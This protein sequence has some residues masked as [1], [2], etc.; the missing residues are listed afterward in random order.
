MPRTL[1]SPPPPVTTGPE[2][3]TAA[4]VDASAL[5][6]VR[7]FGVMLGG[8]LV[9]VGAVAA[10]GVHALRALRA[11]RRPCPAA[12]AVLGTA[13]AYERWMRPRMLRWGATDAEKERPLPGYETG[14][15]PAAHMTNVVQIHAPAEAV[16]AWVAQIGQDRGGFYSYTW[17]ENL[18][19]CRMRNADRVHP[20]WQHRA[21]GETVL[22][23]PATGLKVLRFE[24]G[25]TLVL[26]G[27]WS[28][29]VEPDGPESC[30]LLA[31][32]PAPSGLAATAYGL[33]LE[34]PHFIMQ[35]RMLLEVKRRAEG[36]A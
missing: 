1:N 27:D 20:E 24:P 6:A 5:G 33:L 17:L 21:V 36:T 11:R 15:G 22:L 26:E 28:L 3:G 29:T 32:S 7:A 10:A 12:V 25:H 16:W 19:G 14:A 2:P 18:A 4:K 23:H 8:S 35:R 31:R 34:L 13:A 9:L 30:R